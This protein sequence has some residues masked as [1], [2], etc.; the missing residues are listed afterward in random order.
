MPSERGLSSRV[1]MSE[2]LPLCLPPGPESLPDLH[3]APGLL[4][5]VHALQQGVPHH[6]FQCLVL[7]PPGDLG[8]WTPPG[9][10]GHTC[11]HGTDMQ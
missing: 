1:T 9:R 11:P 2:G 5:A 10:T 7:R 3:P 4:G 6:T 8:H